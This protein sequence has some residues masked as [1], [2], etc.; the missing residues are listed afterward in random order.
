MRGGGFWRRRTCRW[1]LFT[2]DRDPVLLICR[3]NLV[4]NGFREVQL[5]AHGAASA[6]L[7]PHGLGSSPLPRWRASGWWSSRQF[8]SCRSH[9]VR[10]PGDRV[11]KARVFTHSLCSRRGGSGRGRGVLH[12]RDEGQPDHSPG[13][14]TSTLRI[15]HLQCPLRRVV[16]HLLGA[17][18]RGAVD[19]D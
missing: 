1:Y 13:V 9:A 4:R 17:R 14:H 18:S 6:D 10:L 11:G 5:R 19:V 12:C 16:V 3:P 15:K 8:G 7:P 2:G